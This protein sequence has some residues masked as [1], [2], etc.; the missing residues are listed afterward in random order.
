MARI[1]VA[2]VALKSSREIL[3]RLGCSHYGRSNGRERHWPRIGPHTA[4]LEGG[5]DQSSFSTSV[6]RRPSASSHWA[7]IWSRYR[8]TSARRFVWISQI[9]WRPSRLL[10]TSPAC[11]SACR[12]LVIAWRETFA[13]SVRRTIGWGPLAHSRAT[14]FNRVS[15]PSA[16]N[17]GAASAS[18]G[19]AEGRDRDMASKPLSLARPLRGTSRSALSAPSTPA[20]CWRT[21]WPAVPEGSGRSP[22]R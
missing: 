6:R 5:P 9:R 15:S 22:T 10:R 4:W 2:R 16:A 19:A 14:R 8:R 3:L 11:A 12:C 17:T 21:P 13:P 20:R 18:F 7:E 1:S